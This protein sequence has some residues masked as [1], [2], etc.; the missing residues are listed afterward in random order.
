MLEKEI[1]NHLDEIAKDIISKIP[2]KIKDKIYFA[3]GCIYSLANNLQ[4]KDYDLFLVDNSLVDK[5]K[6]LD[7]W[8]YTSEYAL[9]LGKYQIITKYY[10]E[11]YDCVGQFDFKHNM[12]YYK[13]FTG[14]IISANEEEL[15]KQFDCYNFLHTNELIFNENRARD[16]EGV[17]L[18][19]GK[20]VA[21]G[22]IISKQTKKEIKKRT[23]KKSL[24]EYKKSRKSNRNYY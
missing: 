23:T 13:P 24:R 20:F 4:P 16:I 17:F 19:I 12:Y 10:G 11:P 21:R 1:C 6:Q 2:V 22:M 9:T 5:L 15:E 3:G 7:I 14:H 18:R 8:N